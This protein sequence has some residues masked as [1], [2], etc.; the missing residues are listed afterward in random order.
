MY[1][2]KMKT[3]SKRYM[4]P[5]VDSSTIY[6]SQNTAVFIYRSINKDMCMHAQSVLSDFATL[7]TEAC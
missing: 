7:W 1:P 6:N 4:H 2:E 5:K 3:S